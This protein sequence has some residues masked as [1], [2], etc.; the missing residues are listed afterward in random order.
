[1]SN[2]VPKEKFWRSYYSVRTKEEALDAAE[3]ATSW[4][5]DLMGVDLGHDGDHAVAEALKN[6]RAVA[7][8]LRRRDQKGAR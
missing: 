1:M 7:A 4:L 3:Y 6:I 5:Q 8:F 2:G